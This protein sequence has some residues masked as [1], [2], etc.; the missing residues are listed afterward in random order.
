METIILIPDS[1]KGTLTSRQVCEAME[2]AVLRRKPRARVISIPV[3]DGGEGTVEAFLTAMGGERVECTVCGPHFA[4]MTAF[5]GLLPDSTAVIE[6]AACA[7]LP[8]AGKKKNPER[9]TTYGVGQ[10]IMDALDKGAR[11]FLIGLGGS[12][13]NDGGCGC[14]AACGVRFYES[15][16]SSFV[17]SGRNLNEIEKIAMTYADPRLKECTF[18]VLCDIDNPL[19]GPTGAA[20]VFG[21]QKGADEEMVGRLDMGLRHLARRWLEDLGKDLLFLPGGGAAGGMG[22]GMAA[23]FGGTLRPGIDLLLDTV[24][25]DDLAKD[26]SLVFT[27]EGKLDGQTARGKAICGI[28]RRAKGLGLPVIALVGGSEGELAALHSEG[29]TAVFSINRPHTGLYMPRM[30]WKEMYDFSPDSVL[31]VLSNEAYDPDEYIRDY[32]AF[33]SEVNAHA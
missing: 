26:A 31:L 23:F 1:F 27:G 13:T 12:A 11:K 24:G 17:P 20:A 10:L 21:P 22:A 2:R 15:H 25:F 6:M 16:G 5:Y 30:I 8:L 33:V 3:A 32:D 14:A 29:L 9:T 19:C 4:P 28:A 7:G 18:T